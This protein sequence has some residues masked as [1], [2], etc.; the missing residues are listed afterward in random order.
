KNLNDYEKMEAE[1]V[2]F[3]SRIKDVIKRK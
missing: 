2:K 3:V 1:M